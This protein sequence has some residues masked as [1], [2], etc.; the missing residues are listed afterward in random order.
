VL[1][2]AWN[3]LRT[4]GS[5]TDVPALRESFM[6]T[7]LSNANLEWLRAHRRG[8]GALPLAFLRETGFD[9]VS[10][11]T[12]NAASTTASTTLTLTSSDDFETSGV[13]VIWDDNM[14]DVFPW[15]G[16]DESTEILSGI[17]G[18]AW[19]HESGDRVQ[20]MYQLP[21]NFKT[22]RP[23]DEYGDG[24]R[25][26][27]NPVLFMQGPPSVGHFSMYDDGTNKHLWL[28]QGTT[29]QASVFYEKTSSTIDS[30]DDTV[31]VPS[32]YDLFLAWRIVQTAVIPKEGSI[33]SQLYLIA[34]TEANRLLK[35]SLQDRNIG[36][37]VRVRQFSPY[38]A[39]Y[40]PSL[41]VRV[42]RS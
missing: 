32:E 38:R 28:P 21:S 17:S 39:A 5:S 1:G 16:N 40:D 15:T 30:T 3:I 41:L 4:D 11:T 6:L 36:R 14:P 33:P 42:P 37:H 13:G 35:E 23:N 20:T 24:V 26:N 10:D 27:R 31:D 19:A 29:G 2:Y 7:L 18:L 22:F 12:L 8:G 25:I 34:K 9:L